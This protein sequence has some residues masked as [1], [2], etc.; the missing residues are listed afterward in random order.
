MSPWHFHGHLHLCQHLLHSPQL[1][2]LFCQHLVLGHLMWKKIH[3]V[4][5]F[6]ALSAKPLC[7]QLLQLH[8]HW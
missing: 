4:P 6:G 8:L 7:H 1:F 2:V 3:K 5:L